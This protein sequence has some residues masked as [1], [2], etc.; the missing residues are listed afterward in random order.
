VS[1]LST[2]DKRNPTYTHMSVGERVGHNRIFFLDS[3]VFM[4]CPWVSQMENST[5]QKSEISKPTNP[6]KRTMY[7][8]FLPEK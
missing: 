5:E 1:T 6:T 4:E 7:G 3:Y 2:E 8:R